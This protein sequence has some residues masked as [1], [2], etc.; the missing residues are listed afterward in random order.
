MF[1]NNI[2]KLKVGTEGKVLVFPDLFPIHLKMVYFSFL[3]Y[4]EIKERKVLVEDIRLWLAVGV[5]TSKPQ[6]RILQ[7]LSRR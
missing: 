7:G 5:E 2:A 1:H 4:W 3:I 6:G